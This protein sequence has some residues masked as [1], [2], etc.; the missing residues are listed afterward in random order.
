MQ[1]DDLL[2]L[3]DAKVIDRFDRHLKDVEVLLLRG[4]YQGQ[5]YEEIAEANNY[6]ATYLRQDLGPRFWKTLSEALGERVSKRN[7]RSAVERH[8]ADIDEFYL[9]QSTEQLSGQDD[10]N[11]DPEIAVSTGSILD[12]ALH[13]RQDWGDAIDVSVFYGRTHELA[14]LQQWTLQEKCR[15]IALIGMGGIGKTSLSVKLAETIQKQFKYLFWRSLRNAPSADEF[16]TELLFFLSEQKI[17][18]LPKTLEG[19][20]SLAID[21]LRNNR[22]LLILDNFESILQTSS[23]SGAYRLGYEGYGLLLRYISDIAH[24]SCL[25]LTSREKPK[26][27][28]YR[29]G[30][31][32]PVRS[33]LLRGL[34]Q[35]EAREL[36][37]VRGCFGVDDDQLQEIFDHYAGNPLALKMVASV[38]QEMSGGNLAELIPYLRQGQAQ[39]EDIQDLL[40]R[41]INRLTAPEKSLIYWL[42][43][44]RETTTLA[45]LAQDMLD[46]SGIQLLEVVQSLSHRSLL[47]RNGKYLFLQPVVLE[48]ITNALIS[49][50]CSEIQQLQCEFLRDYALLKAQSKDY[51]RQSQLRFIVRPIISRLLEVYKSSQVLE[52]HLKALLGQQQI[53]AAYQPGYVAGNLLNLLCELQAD[54]SGLDCSRLTIWQ[55]YLVGAN[56]HQVNFEQADLS[57]SVFTSVL[58]ATLAVAF[59]PD[60]SLLAMGNADN[61]LRLWNALDYRELLLCEGHESWVSSIAFSPDGQ[62]LASGSLDQTVKLWSVATGSCLATFKGHEGWVWAVAFSPDGQTLVSGS[63]DQTV[64]FWDLTTTQCTQVLQENQGGI[65]AT[66]FS[67]N[68]QILATA[69][70]DRLIRIWDLS[71]GQVIQVLEGHEDWVREV[72]FSPDGNYLV[73]A[74]ND[75]TVRVWDTRTGQC[76]RV[77][78]GNT[79]IV[80]SVALSSDGRTVA[81]GGQD[82]IVRVWDLESGHCLKVLQGHPNGIW[83]VA[84]HPD[85]S[86]LASGSNDSTVKLWNVLTGQSLRTLQGYC[87]GIKAVSFSP[88]G[89]ELASTGDAKVVN[90]W[91]LE[92]DETRL[93]LQGHT[94]WTWC[95]THHPQGNLLASAGNDA[96]IRLWDR[97]T[98]Q[99]LQVLKGHVNLIFSVAFSPDGQWLASGSNDQ[100]V[101]LWD[102]Q[103]G[104]CI[105]SFQHDGRVWTVAF[106]PCG[107]LLASGSND[108]QVRIWDVESGACLKTLAGHSSLVFSVAFSPDGQWL[109]S[110]SDDRTIRIW[111]VRSGDCCKIL[112]GHSGTAWA[113][114][115]SPDGQCLASGGDDKT[116]RIWD[117][118][119]GQCLGTLSG[120]L[121]EVWSVAFSP[122][123]P[124][125]ASGSQD[126]TIRFWDLERQICIKTLAGKKPYDQLNIT[127]CRGLSEAQKE[128]LRALGAIEMG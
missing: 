36:F 40:N 112:A 46:T 50:A 101:K 33:L 87:S 5:S 127:R 125:L 30:I 107:G 61:R 22:C 57:K 85:G 54:L 18:D 12:P 49:Q 16:L 126:G 72:A 102:W 13:L 128:S 118:Q 19:K 114:A 113:I 45:E 105:R 28:A 44:N 67:P 83:S 95:L 124:N 11:N 76:N 60:G 39:F 42:A 70:D 103:N 81:S 109:A 104:A 24:Q 122:K 26:G 51:V 2:K 52:N 100:M 38:V 31:T 62:F 66:T 106:S 111:D 47:E 23:Y 4:A 77:L 14:T 74:S 10:P 116:V 53:S 89:Q 32:L 88:D 90:I 69:G 55:A 3:I 34:T 108:A 71:L 9:E 65:W 92:R 29:E 20:V 15:L 80:T 68:G 75:R 6:T 121:G 78:F 25:I 8:F 41:Q 91:D 94:G 99:A 43:I 123:T 58:N 27:F 1:V 56:L 82:C 79:N 93:S 48:H 35:T 64:R 59:S 98:G 86:T 119:S 117:V 7:F 17:T 115:F 73:S 110:G 63:H 21:Y 96:V 97:A 84:F 120:H 37:Q